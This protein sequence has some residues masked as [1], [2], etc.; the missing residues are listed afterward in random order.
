M[1][2]NDEVGKCPK[3]LNGSFIKM[4]RQYF[5]VSCRYYIRKKRK[6]HTLTDSEVILL[7]EGREIQLNN[8]FFM[9]LQEAKIVIKRPDGVLL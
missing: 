5:C 9:T 8:G 4:E 6:Y 7:L 2:I 1:K 3:C